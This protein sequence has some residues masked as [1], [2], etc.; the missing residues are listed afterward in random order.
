MTT[1]NGWC[2]NDPSN[3]S[4]P[5]GTPFTLDSP[6]ALAYL[7]QLSVMQDYDD[8]TGL[9]AMQML[10]VRRGAAG[11]GDTWSDLDGTFDI[12][13]TRA[14][15]TSRE[16]ITLG[17]GFFTF[18]FNYAP[19]P[20]ELVSLKAIVKDK[21]V[22]VEWM[23]AREE[24]ASHY[25]VERSLNG[26][27]F[28]QIGTVAAT[29]LNAIQSYQFVDVKPVTGN[30]YYRLRQVDQDSTAML[31][32]TVSATIGKAVQQEQVKAEL[33]PNPSSTGNFAIV[34]PAKAGEQVGIIITDMLGK[35]VYQTQTIASEQQIEIHTAGS[36]KTGMYLVHIFTSN[37][38]C[39][40]K[41]IVKQ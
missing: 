37:G 2:C 10:D 5:T 3:P 29:N 9:G 24:N 11:E 20:V 30:N 16:F 13:D 17:N 19:L 18:G 14:T 35:A 36:L 40:K 6:Q 32:K 21:Q 39:V 28:Y 23:I 33:Y 38:K 41:L 8:Y 22:S 12:E 7:T 4:S 31:S 15:I 1:D 27:T 34:V 25:I 26:K